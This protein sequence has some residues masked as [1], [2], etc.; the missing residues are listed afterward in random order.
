MPIICEMAETSW[1]RSKTWC[2]Y[3]K[4]SYLCSDAEIERFHTFPIIIPCSSSISLLPLRASLSELKDCCIGISNMWAADLSRCAC[5]VLALMLC[6][7]IIAVHVSAARVTPLDVGQAVDV[8]RLGEHWILSSVDAERFSKTAS[9]WT[10]KAPGRRSAGTISIV[11][12]G[13]FIRVHN[14]RKQAHM[15]RF[16]VNNDNAFYVA[17]RSTERFEKT[18]FGDGTTYSIHPI[19]THPSVIHFIDL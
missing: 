13:D 10:S 17:P 8:M 4:G 1:N 19:T 3:T 2:L 9:P 18:Y 11:D 12:H 6:T 16:G 15:I 14:L 7:A 5:R